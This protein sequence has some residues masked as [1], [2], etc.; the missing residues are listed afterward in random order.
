MVKKEKSL[1]EQFEIALDGRS[2]RWLSFE[3]RI[4]EAEL[5][6]KINGIIEFTD[7]ELERINKRLGS[8]ISK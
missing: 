5:S 1:K 4:A 2:Q 6:K 8:S 3:V 7:A